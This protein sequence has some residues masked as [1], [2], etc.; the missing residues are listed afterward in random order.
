[1]SN[2]WGAGESAPS[3]RASGSLCRMEGVCRVPPLRPESRAGRQGPIETWSST[4]TPSFVKFVTN[5]VIAGQS[6][7]FGGLYLRLTR[8]HGLWVG[9]YVCVFC[10]LSSI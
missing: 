5:G 3:A 6:F 10:T 4:T 7:N 9:V 8:D 1:M 2:R